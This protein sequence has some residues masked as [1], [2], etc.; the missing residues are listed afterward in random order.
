MEFYQI[1]QALMDEKSLR[2]AD[3]ARISGLPDS[4]VRSILTRRSKTVALDVAFKLADG[5]GVTLEYLNGEQSEPLFENYLLL[6]AQERTF[7]QK[8]RSLD[9][10]S[11]QRLDQYINRLDKETRISV[12]LLQAEHRQQ[13]IA[14]GGK[15]TSGI[16]SQTQQEQLNEL[17][18]KLD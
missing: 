11:Q 6:S 7:I 1:L 17:F 4:T 5:L 9:E 12:L 18:E 8:I 15:T 16:L 10:K 3:V 13:A 14:F 2:I